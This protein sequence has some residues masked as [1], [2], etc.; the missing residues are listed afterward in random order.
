MLSAYRNN[1]KQVDLSRT[2]RLSGLTSGAKLELVQL[3]RSPSVVSVAL[4][5]PESEARDVPNGR[6]TDKFPSTT[7][8]WLVLRKFEAGV[9]GGASVTRNLT[10]RGT[11]GTNQGNSG[12]GRLYYERPVLQ[13]MGRELSSFTDLQRTLGQLGFNNGSTLLRLSFRTTDTPLEEAMIE[14]EEYFKSVEG[15]SGPVA[16]TTPSQSAQETETPQLTDEANN[17]L[18]TEPPASSPQPPDPMTTDPQEPQEPTEPSTSSPL[19]PTTSNPTDRPIVVL[20]PSTSNVPQAALRQHNENDYIPTVDHLKRHQAHLNASTR[21]KRLPTDAEIAATDQASQE[22]LSSV[23]SVEIKIR[24]PDENQV[25]SVFSNED[26]GQT[27]YDFVSH[28]VLDR[29]NE[30]FQ[31]SYFAQGAKGGA[32][33]IPNLEK[34]LVKDLRL[35]GRVLV[36]F[37]WSENASIAARTAKFTVKEELREV[38]QKI[39]VQEPAPVEDAPAPAPLKSQGGNEGKKRGVPKWLKLPGKK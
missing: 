28:R 36:N 18:P 39:E 11:P 31:L 15:E 26:T 24:F 32:T 8:L 13:I 27:L 2:Y 17:V 12:A 9:A 14:I 33:I 21:L 38:A 20:A 22:K 1:N 5:L 6:L 23:K 29:E 19:V 30:P 4:Q 37:L 35:Q 10:A 34:R 3:S 7:T 25:V 16:Q